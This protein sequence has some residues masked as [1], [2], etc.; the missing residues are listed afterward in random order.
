MSKQSLTPDSSMEQIRQL[1]FGQ[2]MEELTR[3]LTALQQELDT[4]KKE[5]GRTTADIQQAIEALKT[6]QQ[7]GDAGA[8]ER[9]TAAETH[10]QQQMAELERRI[11]KMVETLEHSA[12]KRT[13]LAN[14]L[15]ELGER[16]RQGNPVGMPNGQPESGNE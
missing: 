6:A 15:S 14:Y 7:N 4:F 5:S 9:I 3:K 11:G 8:L 16:L 13:A 12:L 10:F 1:L 2:Q